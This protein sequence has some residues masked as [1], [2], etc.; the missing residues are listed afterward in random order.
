MI[1]VWTLNIGSTLVWGSFVVRWSAA[2]NCPRQRMWQRLFTLWLQ[3]WWRLIQVLDIEYWQKQVTTAQ[4]SV[5]YFIL[6][7]VIL[8]YWCVTSFVLCVKIYLAVW[9]GECMQSGQSTHKR[10]LHLMR[11]LWLVTHN[12]SLCYMCVVA[13]VVAAWND[14]RCVN[15]RCAGVQRLFVHDIVWSLGAAIRKVCDRYRNMA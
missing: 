9:T 15:Y 14:Y 1:C 5:K 2:E 7:Y 3:S 12:W 4:V 8:S 13:S 11:P 10:R 6:N